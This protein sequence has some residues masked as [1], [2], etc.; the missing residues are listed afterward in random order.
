MPLVGQAVPHRDAGLGGELLDA[1]LPESAV[2]DAVE[3]AAQHAGGV[4]DGL[5]VAE[6]RA[7]GVEIGDV[8]A[9]VVGAHLEGA[10]RARGGLLEEQRDVPPDEV[11]ALGAGPLGGLQLTGEAEQMGPLLG[12]EVGFLQEAAAVQIH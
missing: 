8:G 7:G 2:L 6:L 3:H 11:L 5:L 9:L 1:L 4:G 12:R 10:A